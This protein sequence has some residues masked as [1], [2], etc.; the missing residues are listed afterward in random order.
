MAEKLYVKQN[1][2]A[3]KSDGF[4]RPNVDV[5]GRTEKTIVSKNGE[6]VIFVIDLGAKGTY[7]CV[8]AVKTLKGFGKNPIA[9]DETGKEFVK[10]NMTMH[11]PASAKEEPTW[12][13]VVAVDE[14]A[15]LTAAQKKAAKLALESVP[16]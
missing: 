12:H 8:F 15:K 10:E 3:D 4:A 13:D 14:P 9:V 2:R 1:I 11:Y 16:A 5:D 7:T 6:Y